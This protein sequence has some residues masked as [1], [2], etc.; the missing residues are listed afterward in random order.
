M[1]PSR[2][3]RPSSRRAPGRGWRSPPRCQPC[4][5]ARAGQGHDGGDPPD[6]PVAR[7]SSCS[8]VPHANPGV[9]VSF[10][11]EHEGRP[12]SS[13]SLTTAAGAG[14]CG[15]PGYGDGRWSG[16]GRRRMAATV[17]QGRSAIREARRRLLAPSERADGAEVADVERSRT[18]SRPAV[19]HGRH[20]GTAPRGGLWRG[21]EA[22]LLAGQPRDDSASVHRG[23]LLG[24]RSGSIRCELEAG[25]PGMW[26]QSWTQLFEWNRSELWPLPAAASN[27]RLGRDAGW[28][29]PAREARTPRHRASGAGPGQR[30]G[31]TGATGAPRFRHGRAIRR[32]I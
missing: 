3:S 14:S 25:H 9:P 13:R 27:E 8:R 1:P 21:R 20:R 6:P 12:S 18:P 5:C 7:I 22:Y 11:A 15:L 10:Q 32:G 31:L 24:A 23:V 4:H 2:C 19:V 16:R 26:H 28:T 17:D 29:A 30:R